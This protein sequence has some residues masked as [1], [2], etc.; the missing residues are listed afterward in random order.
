MGPQPDPNQVPAPKVVRAFL[1]RPTDWRLVTAQENRALG[2][3]R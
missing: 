3:W 1:I 2:R